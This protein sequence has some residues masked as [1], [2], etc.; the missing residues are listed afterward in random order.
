MAV[1]GAEMSEREWLECTDIHLMLPRVYGARQIRLFAVA[2]CRSILGQIVDRRLI[3]AVHAAEQFADGLIS[4]KELDIARRAAW[5]AY[6]DIGGCSKYVKA[7]AAWCAWVATDR[8]GLSD[9]IWCAERVANNVALTPAQANW[10]NNFMENDAP[11]IIRDIVNPFFNGA[12][13]ANN[14]IVGL[15]TVI[16]DDRDYTLM[17]ILGDALEDAGCTDVSVLGHCQSDKPHF[18]GCW[19]VDK[20]LGRE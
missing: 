13:P 3:K 18:R 14:S 4:S 9:H 19:V 15:A 7:S 11:D 6:D 12:I 17:P 2:C 20:I 1:S 10:H 16:Y 8:P 5:R